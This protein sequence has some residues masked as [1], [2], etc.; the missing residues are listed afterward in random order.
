VNQPPAPA[1]HTPASVIPTPLPPIPSHPAWPQPPLQYARTPTAGQ[2]TAVTYGK[3]A[4]IATVLALGLLVPVIVASAMV[5]IQVMG[6]SP[7]PSRPTIEQAQR[8]NEI[9]T[10]RFPWAQGVTYGALFFGLVA[11]GFCIAGLVHHRRGN[12]MIWTCLGLHG[13]LLC[14][15]CGSLLF[16]VAGGMG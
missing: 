2:L 5:N 14:M 7:T 10:A 16:V 6:V 15:T 1:Q 9:M 11:V 8:L 12:W 3:Y 13:V 4:L